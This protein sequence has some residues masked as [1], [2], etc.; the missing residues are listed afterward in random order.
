MRCVDLVLEIERGTLLAVRASVDVH[1]QRIF[2]VRAEI[3]RVSQERFDG[4]F[5][6]IADEVEGFNGLNGLPGEQIVIQIGKLLG[7]RLAGLEI[8][9]G[10]IGWRRERVCQQIAVHRK[11]SDAPALLDNCFRLAAGCGRS[12]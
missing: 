7:R 2:S 9:F 5:V 1:D 12:I 3:R 6:V 11:R 8:Q 4:P 10:L